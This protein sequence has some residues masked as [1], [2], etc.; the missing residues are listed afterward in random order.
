M[1]LTIVLDFNLYNVEFVSEFIFL[2]FYNTTDNEMNFTSSCLYL[3]R[4]IKYF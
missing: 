2:A 3:F 4:V 1:Y